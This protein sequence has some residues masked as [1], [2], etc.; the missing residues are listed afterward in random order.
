[1]IMDGNVG[2]E[3]NQT[4]SSE[5]QET[6]ENLEFPVYGLE[7]TEFSD[8][9]TDEGS[10]NGD[11][12]SF[13]HPTFISPT[14][15]A[16]CPDPTKPCSQIENLI[17]QLQCMSDP[18]SPSCSC[19]TEANQ[20]QPTFWPPP[21][22]TPNLFTT[23]VPI[24]MIWERRFNDELLDTQWTFPRHNIPKVWLKGLSG[25]GVTVVVGDDGLEWK[26]PDLK[27][28]YRADISYDVN[29]DDDDPSPVLFD[30]QGNPRCAPGCIMCTDCPAHGTKCA[31]LIAAKA[32]NGKCIA[33][34]AYN[35]G[36]GGVRMLD[37]NVYDTTEAQTLSMN[38]DKI[39]IFSLSWGPDDDGQMMDSP[40]KLGQEAIE[41]GIQNGRGG[42]GSIYILG[43]GNGAAKGDNCGA[44]GYSNSMYTITFS[45]ANY[46]GRRAHYA[47]SCSAVM[48]TIYGSGQ[49]GRLPQISTIGIDGTCEESFGGTSAVNPIAAGIIA[50]GLEANMDLTW[51]DVQH[52][53]VRSSKA[54][55][56][57][58]TLS[59]SD[60]N[61][62]TNGA[63][64]K[65]STAF[66]FGLIDAEEF[67]Q[68][69]E[70][71]KPIPERL[72]CTFEFGEWI[73]N[74]S[75]PKP[76]NFYDL[77]EGLF[78]LR[79]FGNISSIN[80]NETS[81]PIRYLEHVVV[82]VKIIHPRRGAIQISLNSPMGTESLLLGSR[83]KDYSNKSLGIERPHDNGWNMNSVQHWGENPLGDWKLEILDKRRNYYP[84]ADRILLS[85]RLHLFGTSEPIVND[86]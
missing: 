4:E 1:M 55:L 41:Q 45:A 76:T 11:P 86:Y 34:V 51:R 53:V 46:N 84:Q 65:T 60:A 81:C 22:F 40:R 33:G 37:S 64:Y 66:G 17:H 85:W 44:D 43:S 42:K 32:D 74:Q 6:L 14:F 29:D 72:N 57:N 48:S 36:I 8:P 25:K 50:L 10:S 3:K 79:S 78:G 77:E 30:S 26:H 5:N 59:A 23:A 20:P 19:C 15:G 56:N 63:G 39:D 82:G 68:R 2:Q 73:V 52:L 75:D 27:D 7:T 71:W 24:N 70:K 69:S 80:V 58:M 62:Q 18:N 16:I 67:V 49:P 54:T 9:Q 31:G 38:R 61:W 21:Q 13:T 12:M 28:N 47:E 83:K 35:A